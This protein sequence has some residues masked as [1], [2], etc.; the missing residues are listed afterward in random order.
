[1]PTR[2]A[3][4]ALVSSRPTSSRSRRCWRSARPPC[5]PKNDRYRVVTELT[6]IRDIKSLYE[7]IGRG[8]DYRLDDRTSDDDDDDDD[9]KKR[10]D[11]VYNKR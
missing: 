9:V 10:A 5:G 11:D 7:S 1:M 6:A 3:L 2:R 4:I 8:A